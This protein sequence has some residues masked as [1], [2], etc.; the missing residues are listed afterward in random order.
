MLKY[1]DGHLQPLVR[2]RIVRHVQHCPHCGHL[3]RLLTTPEQVL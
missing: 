2:K 1:W 3:E